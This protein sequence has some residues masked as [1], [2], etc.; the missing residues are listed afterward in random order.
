MQPIFQP[1]QMP[2][3]QCPPGFVAGQPEVVGNVL[4]A[5]FLQV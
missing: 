2:P 3:L 5:I 1:E 4:D